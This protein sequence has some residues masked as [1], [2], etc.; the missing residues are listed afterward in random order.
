VLP[1]GSSAPVAADTAHP[2]TDRPSCRWGELPI[3][4]PAQGASGSE[5]D[6]EVPAAVLP[7]GHRHVELLAEHAEA[8]RAVAVV[9]RLDHR[10][11]DRVEGTRLELLGVLAEGGLR[12]VGALLAALTLG[13][14]ARRGVQDHPAGGLPVL[15]VEHVQQIHEALGGGLEVLLAIGALPGGRIGGTA[16]IGRTLVR[17]RGAGRGAPAVRGLLL[18]TGAG[19]RAPQQGDGADARGDAP[20]D[21]AHRRAHACPPP[22]SP[23]PCSAPGWH[24]LARR[25]PMQDAP[26]ARR[27]TRG[28]RSGPGAGPTLRRS[29]PMSRYHSPSSASTNGIGNS[30]P[31]IETE[32]VPSPL[33]MTS[34]PDSSTASRALDSRPCSSAPP[35][36][37]HSVRVSPSSGSPVVGSMKNEQTASESPSSRCVTSSMKRSVAASSTAWARGSSAVSAPSSS[38]DSSAASPSSEGAL[39]ALSSSALSSSAPSTSAS[40]PSASSPPWPSAGSSAAGSFPPSSPPA[41]SSVPPQADA[42]RTSARAPNPMA[43]P[44]T[45]RRMIVFT[46]ASPLS[47]RGTSPVTHRMPWSQAERRCGPVVRTVPLLRRGAGAH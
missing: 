20:Q 39:S 45:L 25:A 4:V 1:L 19:C 6:D 17:L 35:S 16:G 21:A 11:V 47:T 31:S 14:D 15:V 42:P 26:R 44:L 32:T 2:D 28:A 33:S 29:Q 9:V 12:A 37:A 34:S 36:S 41:T 43:A 23:R 46:V 40:A 8:D 18:G 27:G 30:L 24:T 3:N 10:G 13:R 7:R 38:A 22:G 5:R